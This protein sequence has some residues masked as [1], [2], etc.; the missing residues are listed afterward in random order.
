MTEASKKTH[1][2][3]N[4]LLTVLFS[5]C[6]FTLFITGVVKADLLVSVAEKRALTKFPKL[7]KTAIDIQRYPVQYNAYYADHFGYRDWLVQRYKSLKFKIGD[8]P[9][10]NVVIG[11]D[12]WLFLGSIQDGTKANNDPIGDV[13]N[14]NLYTE[15]DLKN[16]AAN[17][18]ATQ[19]KLQNQ[20]IE[21][22]FVIAPN[23][24]TIY[25]EKLPSYIT[26]SQALSA[27]DQLFSYL[28]AHTD[29]NILD[30][31]TPLLKAKQT[32]KEPLYYKLDSHWNHLGANIGQYE[33]MKVVEKTFPNDIHASL[34]TFK[35]DRRA[36]KDLAVYLGQPKLKDNDPRPVFKNTCILQRSP[37][38]YVPRGTRTWTCDNQKLTGLMFGDSYFNHMEPYFSRKLLRSTFVKSR[39]NHTVLDQ[40]IVK[41][42][43]DFVI[44]EWVERLLP[45]PYAK[46]EVTQKPKVPL[47]LSQLKTAFEKSDKTIYTLEPS[48]LKYHMIDVKTTKPDALD[49]VSMGLDP[50]IMLPP[51]DV[52]P[53]EHYVVH[54]NITSPVNSLM[55]VYYSVKTTV[56][57]PFTENHVSAHTI[58]VGE[59]DIY[60]PLSH[61]D[62]NVYYRIDPLNQ[63]GEFTLSALEIRRITP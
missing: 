16:F 37:K 30:L 13:R 32:S 40:E 22:L 9:S 54:I 43:P 28:Q 12:G 38:K 6:I 55:S 59:N 7:P 15:E 18:S 11:K 33:I 60:I 5:A 49:L 51:L 36:G 61:P 39:L 23:K 17:I 34:Q 31:R 53:R 63:A 20:G 47:T 10:K 27:T 56:G 41:N 44:E 50:I 46:L 8:S 58:S 29:V 62:L 57:Y 1:K 35:P 24:H 14:I 48:G 42:K 21:Y 52:K 4:L 2:Y 3:Y 45:L 19:T 25:F 26:K